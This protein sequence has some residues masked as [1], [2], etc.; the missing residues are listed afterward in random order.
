MSTQAMS[1][2]GAKPA[3]ASAFH[4][5]FIVAWLFC[6]LFYFMEYAVR[7][8]PSVMLPELT[9]AFGLN[10]VGLSSLIGLY[11]YSYAAFAIVAGASVDRWGA[12]YTIPAGLLILAVGTAMFAVNVGWIA[13][14]GRFLQ[15]AG[16]AFAFVAAVYLAARGLPARY[17]A[18]AVGITQC[19]GMLGGAAG[20]FVVAPLIHGPLEWQ[21]FWVYAGAVTLLIAVAMVIVTPREHLS[22]GSNASIWTTFAPYKTVLT[23]PQSYLCGLCGGLLFLP[24]TV[25][26]MTWGV[27]F[28]QEGWHVAYTPAVDRAAAVAIGWVFGCPILGYVADRIGGARGRGLDA[29]GDPG[30]LLPAARDVS[31]IP[32]RLPAWLRVRRRDDPLFDHQGGEPGSCEGQRHRC[33]ELPG[34]CDDRIGGAR[35]R[36][37]DAKARGRRGVDG[38]CL[39]H[40]RQRLCR[41]DC[42]SCVPHALSEGNR[43]GRSQGALIRCRRDEP[44][45][46]HPMTV[47]DLLDFQE[48]MLCACVRNA[49]TFATL[50]CHF[51]QEMR[52]IRVRSTR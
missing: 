24:T 8:A 19:L 9:T 48:L 20:Q 7:S 39:R 29:P 30:D 25:G 36:L 50:P 46:S 5:A 14:V 33:D 10:T 6:L 38:G 22:Q 32:A 52:R 4:T 17:L 31:S 11:Y 49:M 27:S 21:Q 42:C 41:G 3:T 43:V 16:A 51:A 34:L 37:V 28:L 45:R 23:N 40:G 2:G 13:G 47:R 26:A 12:K 15:G 18:T 1:I 44:V 35:D